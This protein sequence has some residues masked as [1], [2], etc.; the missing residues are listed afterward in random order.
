MKK[1]TY[2]SLA[3]MLTGLLAV[4]SQA[5]A[6]HNGDHDTEPQKPRNPKYL[7][8]SPTAQKYTT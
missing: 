4:Q 1:R 8:K 3:C 5:F 6:K 7:V 2:V